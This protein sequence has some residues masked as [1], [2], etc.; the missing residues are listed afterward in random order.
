MATEKIIL[1]KINRKLWS[2]CSK[3]SKKYDFI[4]G[5]S[6]GFHPNQNILH[7][8]WLSLKY[9]HTNIHEKEHYF[10]GKIL[11]VGCGKKPYASWFKNATEYVGLD[12]GDNI[13]AD[14]IV[15]ENN[16]WPLS[17]STFDCVVSFQSFEHIED[18]SHV[19]TEI[20]RVLKKN[21]LI[22]ITVPFI[23]YEHAAP[24][25]YRRASK[26]GISQFF[27]KYKFL[28]VIP[29][30]KIGSTIGTLVLRFIKVSMKKTI[31]TRLLF[32]ILLPLWILV[33]LVINISSIFVDLIDKTDNFYSNVLLIAK[34]SF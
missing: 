34:K 5:L 12:I 2:F 23:A 9:I 1:S 20:N 3:I 16:K 31:L 14:Y 7:E 29:E 24:S 33:T 15:N 26:Y 11:D 17:N 32:M 21:G 25:D 13:N 27:P 18:I 28:E 4:Y 10:T 6:C 30:G 8:E 19:T 22:L